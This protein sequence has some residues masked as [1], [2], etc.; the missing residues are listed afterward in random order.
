MTSIVKSLP[1]YIKD[2]NHALEI[3]R[4]FNFSGEENHFHYEQNIF[5]HCNPKQ[6]RLPSTQML[7]E[8]TSC[9][10]PSSET[11]LRLAEL[12]LT[13][14]CFPIGDNCN[15]QINGVAMGTKMG[16][17]Y[18]NLFADYTENKFFLNYH[19]PKPD[20]INDNDLS[21]SVHYKLT[22]SHNYLLH[23]SSHS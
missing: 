14:K 3:F 15:K 22:D 20:L 4:T 21:T 17:S 23:S 9:Q 7:F 12:V 19:G 10:K 16:P 1:W 18:V 8:P 13:Y 5:T 2:N 11:L 6:W